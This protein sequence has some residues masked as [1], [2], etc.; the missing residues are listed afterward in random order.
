MIRYNAEPLLWS[1]LNNDRFLDALTITT[2][3]ENTLKH[4]RNLARK[5]I[6]N[7]FTQ[8]RESIKQNRFMKEL[9][10]ATPQEIELL[11]QLT[12]KFWPQGSGVYKT[13]NSPAWSPP[14]QIDYDDGAYLPMSV[15]EN[16]PIAQ[17][18]LFFNIVDSALEQ[19]AREQ[20]W[21]FDN[22]KE[23][24]SRLIINN[25]IHLDVPLYAI[26]EDRYDA[27]KLAMNQQQSKGLFNYTEDSQ[28]IYLKPDEV[29]LAVR[30]QEHWKQSDPMKIQAWFKEAIQRHGERLRRVCRYLKAWRDHNWRDGGGPSSIVLMVCATK[31]FDLQGEKFSRDCEALAAVS[32]QLPTLL[33]SEIRNPADIE[34]I[35]YPR[36]KDNIQA[37]TSAAQLLNTYLTNALQKSNNSAEVVQNI[38]HALGNRVPDRTDLVKGISVAAVVRSTKPAAQPAPEVTNTMRSG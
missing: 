31:V 21:G 12:P 14:Q 2:Q 35:M 4:C 18:E 15:I 16:N 30:S 23:T 3:E 33:S 6:R 1:R 24:C 9:V 38:I 22:K 20:G 37:N 36:K 10:L 13:M 34:E 5:A 32:A 25:R 26:P 11:K 17:K 28:P 27:L 7:K 29:Y 8:V 19:L